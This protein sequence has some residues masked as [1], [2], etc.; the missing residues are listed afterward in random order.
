MTRKTM[1]DLKTGMCRWPIG[2]PK[3]EDFHFCGKPS[4]TGSI[5][6]DEHMDAAHN[7]KS[8]SRD[9]SRTA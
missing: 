4:D 6:C 5:Y 1:N 8:G 3:D 9:K 2:D 7:T